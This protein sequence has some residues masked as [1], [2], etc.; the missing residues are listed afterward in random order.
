MPGGVTVIGGRPGMGKTALATGMLEAVA[1]VRVGGEVLGGAMFSLE[2]PREGIALRQAASRAR[3]NIKPLKSGRNITDAAWKAIT[4]ASVDLSR[5]PFWIDD[6]PGLSPMVLRAKARQVR[7]DFARRGVRLAVVVVDYLQ[8]MAATGLPRG[9]NRE[10]EVAHCSKKLKELAKE[11]GVHVVAL[12]QLN[13]GVEAHGKKD[14]RPRMADLRE[15]GSVEQDADNIVL[16][17]REDY[18]NPACGPQD[19]GVAELL[20][21]KQRDGERGVVKVKFTDWCTRFDDL[22]GETWDAWQGD[23]RE[24]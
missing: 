4:D 19:K 1:G 10:Q 13:R 6:T 23:D 16:V 17:Y 14:R 5:M 12:S 8:L 21:E 2:M 3:V 7:A 9:S 18:Y 11:L 20:I 15:S 22:T 24:Q